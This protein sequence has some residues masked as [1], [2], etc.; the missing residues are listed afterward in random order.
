MLG[1]YIR[2]SPAASSSGLFGEGGGE[3]A[4]IAELHLWDL[5]D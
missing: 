4:T 5:S 2:G 1:G 3:S